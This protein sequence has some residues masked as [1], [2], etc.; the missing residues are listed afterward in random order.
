[1]KCICYGLYGGPEN[2]K[3]DL[4][5]NENGSQQSP[6]KSLIDLDL[7]QVIVRKAVATVVGNRVEHAFQDGNDRSAG[8]PDENRVTP[9]ESS[10]SRE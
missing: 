9:A 4:N 3:G 7:D 8:N 10:E 2:S 6:L 5:A 1:M